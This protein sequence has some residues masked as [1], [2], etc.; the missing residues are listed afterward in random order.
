MSRR[1]DGLIDSKSSRSFQVE[2]IGENDRLDRPILVFYRASSNTSAVLAVIILS[3]RLSVCMSVRL[4][5]RPSVTRV[6]CDKNQAM[7]C[8]YFDTTRKGYH[9]SFLTLT[10]VGGRRHLPSEIWAQSNPPPSKNADV[11]RF[12]LITSQRKR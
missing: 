3:V 4:F 7:H 10:V 5:V 12:P 9:S 1:L 6:L 8:G 2:S 11:D